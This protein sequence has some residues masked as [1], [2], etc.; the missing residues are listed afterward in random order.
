MK[1]QDSFDAC[2][3]PWNRRQRRR[4]LAS[5]GVIVNLFAGKDYK[6]WSKTDWGGFE[7][8]NVDVTMDLH[9]VGTWGYLCHLARRGLVVA[10]LG[11]PPCRTVS[12]LRHRAPGPRP[13]RGRDDRRFMLEGLSLPERELALSDC[14]L[15]MKQIGL[16]L[17]ADEH[18]GERPEPGFLMESPRDPM[19]YMPNEA[20]K[21]DMPSLWNLK[22]TGPIEGVVGLGT[23]LGGGGEGVL[24]ELPPGL[25]A[26]VGC[27]GDRASRRTRSETDER[28]K[29]ES[30]R[31]E[32]TST[33]QEGLSAMHGADGRGCASPE[34]VRRSIG[35]LPVL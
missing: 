17:L 12:R 14:A 32:P 1:G 28:G 9:G 13:L 6:S 10:V 22:E 31:A 33:L 16:W 7:I 8:L 3:C 30:P 15:M 29:L 23:G 26:Q 24:E 18:R 11:G 21:E 35:L 20:T 27:G 2:T 5:R 34:D 4:H 25:Q 19:D